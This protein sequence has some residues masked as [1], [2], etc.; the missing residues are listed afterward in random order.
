MIT[1]RSRDRSSPGRLQFHRADIR[2]H[3]TGM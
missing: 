2:L 1:G 3:R